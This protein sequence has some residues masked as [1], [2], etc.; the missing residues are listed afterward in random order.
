MPWFDIIWNYEPGGNVE[1]IAQHG[2]TPEDVETVVCNPLGKTTSRTSG[3]PAVTGYTEDG[4]LIIVVY[5]EIDDVTIYP[6]TA[7]EI[8][9]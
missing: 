8:D 6:I 1:Y 5:E 3:R 4:R 7:F 2:I 9:E